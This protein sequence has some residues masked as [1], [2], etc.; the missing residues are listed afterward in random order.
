MFCLVED[1]KIH[2][3]SV[4]IGFLGRA[5]AQMENI[6]KTLFEGDGTAIPNDYTMSP[7]GGLPS[8]SQRP[9]QPP[10][11]QQGGGPQY[12]PQNYGGYPRGNVPGPRVNQPYPHRGAQP[13]QYQNMPPPGR[14]GPPQG[15][16][17]QSQWGQQQAGAQQRQAQQ[18]QQYGQRPPGAPGQG[19]GGQG[20]ATG[21][22]QQAPNQYGSRPPLPPQGTQQQQRPPQGQQGAM[23]QQRPQG[24]PNQ[25]GYPNP[26]PNTGGW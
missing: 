17:L 1:M 24:Q 26:N 8:Q 21:Y 2:F 19:Y 23:N 22:G 14:G 11:M 12:P 20:G 9:N 4:L 3:I 16:P 10:Q 13:N 6:Q 25:G 7:F 15:P 5:R 18:Q